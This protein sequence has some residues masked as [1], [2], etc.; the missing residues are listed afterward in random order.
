MVLLIAAVYLL[1]NVS[2]DSGLKPGQPV[3][4]VRQEGA[5]A[6]RK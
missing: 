6:G 2:V 4:D 1:K 5:R 3:I